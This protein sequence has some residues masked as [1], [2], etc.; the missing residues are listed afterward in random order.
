LKI[1]EPD[2]L[3][4]HADCWTARQAP[5]FSVVNVHAKEIPAPTARIFPQLGSH[6]LLSPGPFW[7]FLLGF[8]AVIGKLFGWDPGLSNLNPQ[9][10]EPGKYFAFFHVIYVDAPREVGMTVENRL[11]RALMSW[12][13]RE[14]SG[15]TMVYNVT[16]A[17]FKG[18]QGR[19]YW[20]VIRPFHDGLIEDSLRLFSRRVEER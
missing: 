11:S 17:N 14:N 5:E 7:K 1:F 8:R 13:L 20:Q 16:C 9:A 2:F 10:I 18:R 19:H 12:V 4:A 3:R 6:D 15:G